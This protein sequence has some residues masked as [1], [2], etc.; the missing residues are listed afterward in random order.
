MELQ[1]L[2]QKQKSIMEKIDKE[3]KPADK[4][5]NMLMQDDEMLALLK[6]KIAEKNMAELGL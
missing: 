3:R 6:K 5:L 2:E 1:A 4:L